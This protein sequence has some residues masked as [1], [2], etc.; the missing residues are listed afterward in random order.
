MNKKRTSDFKMSKPAKIHNPDFQRCSD[1][2][3]KKTNKQT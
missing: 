2:K 1:S 3:K